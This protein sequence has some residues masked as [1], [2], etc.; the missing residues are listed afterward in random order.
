M[1]KLSLALGIA[2]AGLT[3]SLA[4]AQ[5]G[6]YGP[7]PGP[8]CGGG[9]VAAGASCPMG[10]GGYGPGY[11]RGGGRGQG[12]GAGNALLTQEEFAA[13]REKMHSFKSVEECN[14]YLAEHQKLMAERAKEKGVAAPPGPHGNACERMKAHGMFG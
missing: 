11:G 13:H 3:A 1:T 14:A 4:L 12:S 10:G 6:G 2:V 9:P 5:G 7:G 8:G